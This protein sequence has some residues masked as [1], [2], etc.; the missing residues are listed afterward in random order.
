[1]LFYHHS[2]YINYV[3][4]QPFASCSHK[5]VSKQQTFN[6]KEDLDINRRIIE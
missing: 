3:K 4:L 5:L 1:M 6:M 2:D